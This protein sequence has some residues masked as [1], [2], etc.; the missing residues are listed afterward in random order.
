MP[1]SP[2]FLLPLLPTNLS[3]SFTFNILPQPSVYTLVHFSVTIS[4]GLSQRCPLYIYVSPF[5]SLIRLYYMIYLHIHAHNQPCDNLHLITYVLFLDW[6][7]KDKRAS[8][9]IR[10]PS[11]WYMQGNEEGNTPAK[12]DIWKRSLDFHINPTW[13]R[14]NKSGKKEMPTSST[15]QPMQTWA[16]VG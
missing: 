14:P 16:T 6:T 12:N 4:E 9:S 13:H 15:Y 10:S 1:P 7:F 11:Y 5:P 8:F 3:I 2:I